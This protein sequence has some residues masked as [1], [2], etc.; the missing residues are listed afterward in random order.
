MV[1]FDPLIAIHTDDHDVVF[2]ERP[3]H[4]PEEE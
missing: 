4:E 3:R 2:G 1:A